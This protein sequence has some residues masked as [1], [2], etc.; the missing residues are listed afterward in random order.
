MERKCA[1]VNNGGTITSLNGGISIQAQAE[2]LFRQTGGVVIRV[3]PAHSLPPHNYPHIN[4]ETGSGVR[5]T[6]RILGV[7]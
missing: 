7:E 4:Y 2:Q 5:G 3:E 6:L 1:T